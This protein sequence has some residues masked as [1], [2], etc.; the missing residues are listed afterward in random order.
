[1]EQFVSWINAK[2]ELPVPIKAGSRI[3]SSPQYTLTTTA[4]D[5]QRV[6]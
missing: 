5:E 1:M 4:T 3:T 2:D 6:C